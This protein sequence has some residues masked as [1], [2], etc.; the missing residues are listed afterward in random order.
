MK[1]WL[2]YHKTGSSKFIQCMSFIKAANEIKPL[3]M[4]VRDVFGDILKKIITFSIC[5]HI[6]KTS[7]TYGSHW[8]YVAFILFNHI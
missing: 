8:L 2:S 5:F 3:F 6:W 7:L 1:K 4:K